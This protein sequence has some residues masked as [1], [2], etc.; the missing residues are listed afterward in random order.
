ML[1]IIYI[2]QLPIAMRYSEWHISEFEKQFCK[3]FDSVI[4]LGKRSLERFSSR[5]FR[6]KTG[7]FSSTEFAVWFETEQ[8]KEYMMLK[9]QDNDVLF[10]ADLS[11]PGFF[12]NVLYHKRPRKC[13]AFCHATSKNCYDYFQPVR[14]SKWA[15]EY[16]H[17]K[18][19][20]KVFV[21][22]FYH[23][24]KLGKKWK[25]TIITSLPNPPFK[26]Y[27]S[28]KKIRNIISVARPSL[29]KINKKLE[30]DIERKFGK[31]WRETFNHWTDYYNYISESRVMLIS[32]KEE[33]YGY[34]VIDAVLNNCIPI[35]P[36]KFSYQE[37]LPREYLYYNKDELYEIVRKALNKKLVVPQLINQYLIED[38]W[39][40]I[41]ITMKG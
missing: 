6:D 9:L 15:A 10:L 23:L 2:P 8:I 41:I 13:F 26:T 37:I 5:H 14:K 17:S 39:T 40:N 3:H 18:M 12:T 4:T 32:A 27:T 7:D 36:N 20:D 35:A 16:A 22:T 30:K 38:F 19:F 28:K 24:L 1:R 34:Q 11:F 29:Q 31:I 25:N 33:T 21:A